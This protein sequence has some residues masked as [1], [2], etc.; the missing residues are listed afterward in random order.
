MQVCCFTIKRPI[1]NNIDVSVVYKE[2]GDNIPKYN[3]LEGGDYLGPEYLCCV[4]ANIN[5]KSICDKYNY[6]LRGSY[7]M[8]IDPSNYNS[9]YSIHSVWTCSKHELPFMLRID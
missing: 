5:I 4:D 3:A 7:K 8:N 2:F 9:N 6:V 1:N